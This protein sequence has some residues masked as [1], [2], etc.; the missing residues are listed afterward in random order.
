MFS[1]HSVIHVQLND[2]VNRRE[3]QSNQNAPEVQY[4]H[5]SHNG[6]QQKRLLILTFKG[7]DGIQKF[8]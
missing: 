6:V 5:F 1:Y 3:D 2:H 8:I 4:F 7:S